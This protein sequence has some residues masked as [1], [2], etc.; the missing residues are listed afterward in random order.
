LLR[1]KLTLL[2]ASRPPYSRVSSVASTV[3]LSMATII[4]IINN[5][6]DHSIGNIL[7]AKRAHHLGDFAMGCYGFI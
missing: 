1:V 3:K 5:V 4:S 7:L 6:A 2:T